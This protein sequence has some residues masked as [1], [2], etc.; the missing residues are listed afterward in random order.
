MQKESKHAKYLTN[1]II[2]KQ[3]VGNFFSEIGKL[4]NSIH[5]ENILDVGCGEGF[6]LNYLNSIKKITKASAIDVDP[7]E[8]KDA[9]QNLPFCNVMEASAYELPFKDNEFDLVICSEVLE[10]LEEPEKAIQEINRVANKYILLSVPN[11]PIWRILNMARFKYWNK[12]GNTPG[13]INNWSSRQFVKIVSKYFKIN[14]IK[15][16]LPW[17]VLLCF[18]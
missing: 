18:K 6:I 14:L 3:L 11:E 9:K 16:P 4:Y 1:N 12:L 10:H 15:K 13:H 2:S 7:D 5:V 17:T 8:I